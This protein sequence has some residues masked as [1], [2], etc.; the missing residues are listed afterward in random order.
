MVDRESA[1]ITRTVTRQWSEVIA[2]LGRLRPSAEAKPTDGYSIF[3][4][5]NAV[6][7]DVVALEIRPVVF[8]VP[9]RGYHREA[10]ELFI[11]VKGDMS[12]RRQEFIDTGELVTHSF[13]TQVGYFRRKDE[14]FSHVYGAHYDFALSDL[15]H[16][17]FHAQLR[18]F[19]ELAAHIH[20]YYGYA[21][22]E[23]TDLVSGLLRTV[24]IPTAQ[25]DA[26]SLFLQ[27]CADHLLSEKSGPEEK[28]AF[29]SLLQKS[30]FCRGAA[31]QLPR[32]ATEEARACYRARHWYPAIA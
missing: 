9:E 18:S 23:V 11:V 17:V 29:N 32:L 1:M 24:R 20:E 12:F 3:R 10:N 30:R 2:E 31:G 19:V 28:R 4:T 7:A 21:T 5:T 6:G 22:D 8:N 16:P 27:I 14:G 15:G 25:L 26:F 13:G